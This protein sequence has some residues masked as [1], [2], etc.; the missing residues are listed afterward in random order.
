MPAR[1]SIILASTSP[2]RIDLLT[3][4]GLKP[5]VMAP[6]VDEA[7]LPRETPRAMVARLALL[8][9]QAVLA[10]V[11]EPALIIAADT[12]VVAP[13]GKLVLGKPRDARDARR[14]L[15]LLSGRTHT[16]LTGFCILPT[17]P[18][19]RAVVRVVTS[20]VR[21]RAL[22]KR[23]IAAYV[24]TGEPMDKAGSYAAQG[25]GT[26]LIE[27]LSGSY[28]NVVGLPI[29]QVLQILEIQFGLGLFK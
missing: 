9:A 2:R 16:V 19:G 23:G 18:G 25:I 6:D 20:R 5:R 11:R 4:A 26:A 7:R 10:R 29:C 27:S 28:S 24:A 21:M 1:I 17:Q 12:T 22:S 15:A 3:Q 14:M 13:G 8:K